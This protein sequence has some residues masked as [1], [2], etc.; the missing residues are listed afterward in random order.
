[1]VTHRQH[2]ERTVGHGPATP[3]WLV[4]TVVAAIVGAVAIGA[5]IRAND[6]T[7]APAS[8]AFMPSV[9]PSPGASGSYDFG[10]QTGRLNGHV[11]L[12]FKGPA[13]KEFVAWGGAVWSA[14][15]VAETFGIDLDALLAAGFVDAY[16]TAWFDAW[17]AID[18]RDLVS[19]TMLFDSPPG[20][21]RVYQRLK[22]PD[23][24]RMHFLPDP[25][26]GRA[27][28]A[29]RGRYEGDRTVAYVWVIGDELAIVASQGTGHTPALAT[30]VMRRLA[31]RVSR[32]IAFGL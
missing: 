25:K 26:L 18:G 15:D 6:E 4:V 23:V 5:A 30:N 31:E 19:V 20:A 27:S 16:G 11:V 14:V 12:A 8:P 2:H 7:V 22:A 32:Q 1:M 3:A 9:P 28:H 24:R 10:S 21:F 29:W 17:G 13:A